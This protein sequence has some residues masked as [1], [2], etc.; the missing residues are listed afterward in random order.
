MSS[1]SPRFACCLRAW[2]AIRA[3]PWNTLGSIV[4]IANARRPAL[5]MIQAATRGLLCRRRLFGAR[6]RIKA[7]V[8]GARLSESGVTN[9]AIASEHRY[10]LRYH[11][12]WEVEHRF[13]DWVAL[14]MR[15]SRHL[16]Q[17]P[18]LPPRL[19]RTAS[20]FRTRA[21]EF[22]LQQVLRLSTE[23]QHARGELLDF[24]T[25]SHL[26]WQYA[27]AGPLRV[28]SEA[29]RAT[30]PAFP[31]R[32]DVAPRRL[33]ASDAR[34][35]PA[36]GADPLFRSMHD[37]VAVSDARGNE[38]GAMRSRWLPKGKPRENVDYWLG[39]LGT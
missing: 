24:L 6:H 20:A 32:V 36:R 37:L 28:P 5:L 26:H 2:K 8:C 10:G 22:Y 19:W 27:S 15:L 11:R 30:L 21:L 29:G 13:S 18:S 33:A 7:A 34:H 4:T 31:K 12:T 25:T 14:D 35:Q 38:L 1:R 9:Y 3:R 16:K 17:R 23:A 39:V